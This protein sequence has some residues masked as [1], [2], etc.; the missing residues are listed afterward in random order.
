MVVFI[1]FLF[2]QGEV[3]IKEGFK[4]VPENSVGSVYVI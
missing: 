1:K 2:A 4:C 3:K